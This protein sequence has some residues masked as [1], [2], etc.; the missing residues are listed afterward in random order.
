MLRNPMLIFDFRVTVTARSS[1]LYNRLN[2]I[3]N[4][5]E[6][7]QL[8]VIMVYARTTSVSSSEVKNAELAGKMD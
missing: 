7:L 4:V 1:K 8:K 5:L 6:S 3:L 2:S